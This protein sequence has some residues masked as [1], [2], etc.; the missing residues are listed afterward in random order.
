MGFWDD[1]KANL[2]NAKTELDRAK[3]INKSLT[4]K[5]NCEVVNGANHIFTKHFSMGRTPDGYALINQKYKVKIITCSDYQETHIGKSAG[6]KIAGAAVGGFLTGGPG[7]IVGALAVGNNKKN[8]EKYDK[9]VAVD[10]NGF[11]HEV[12]LKPAFMQRSIINSKYLR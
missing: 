10:E 2:N 1:V 4:D 5:I 12:I 3:E 8:T 6:K 7:A 11:T 9:L